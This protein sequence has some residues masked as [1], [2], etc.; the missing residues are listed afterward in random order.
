MGTCGIWF[1]WRRRRDSFCIVGGRLILFPLWGTTSLG[2]RTFFFE[3]E[4]WA[5]SRGMLDGGNRPHV[6]I[7]QFRKLVNVLSE[8]SYGNETLLVRC[9]TCQRR[10]GMGPSFGVA[11]VGGLLDL[12]CPNRRGFDRSGALRDT[13]SGSKRL[14]FR[15]LFA[16]DGILERGPQSMRDNTSP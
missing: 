3:S 12:L 7:R 5:G 16:C 8:T 4:Q 2:F 13:C 15:R 9:T 6:D 10:L 14:R 11:R 1:G